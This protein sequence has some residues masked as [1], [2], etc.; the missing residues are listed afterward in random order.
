MQLLGTSSPKRPI[1]G[2]CPWTPLGRKLCVEST[3]LLKLNYVIETNTVM[4]KTLLTV[5]L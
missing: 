1:P 5:K 2:L 3:K 4:Y